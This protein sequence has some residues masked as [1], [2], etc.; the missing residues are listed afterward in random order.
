MSAA[1]DKKAAAEAAAKADEKFL[2]EMAS[3]AYDVRGP[4]M[5]T[6]LRGDQLNRL[7]RL[8]QEAREERDKLAAAKP[9]GGRGKAP[10]PAWTDPLGELLPVVNDILESG[11]DL[12]GTPLVDALPAYAE[13]QHIELPDTW[14]PA[15]AQ[16]LSGG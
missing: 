16:A 7:V 8:A 10:E 6:T 12:W 5:G 3:I 11:T 9:K 13:A 1:S 14:L 15:V 4:G 2:G